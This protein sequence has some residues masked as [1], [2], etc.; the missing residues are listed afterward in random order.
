L[1]HGTCDQVPEKVK[2]YGRTILQ[3][4]VNLYPRITTSVS[5]P[6]SDSIRSVDPDL[7]TGEQKLPKK[8]KKINKKFHVL[9]CW[10]P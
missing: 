7:D 3:T 10:Q 2:F 5:D 8:K 1:G 6:Y 9:K 4:F